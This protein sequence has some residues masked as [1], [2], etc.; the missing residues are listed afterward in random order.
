MRCT[1]YVAASSRLYLM[2]TRL[3]PQMADLVMGEYNPET[4]FNDNDINLVVIVSDTTYSKPYIRVPTFFKL[5]SL[6][7]GYAQSREM[8]ARK[9]LSKLTVLD[10]F[11]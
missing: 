6:T 8:E 3:S 9:S 11:R 2:Q 10:T 1:L 5:L 4:I 7:S